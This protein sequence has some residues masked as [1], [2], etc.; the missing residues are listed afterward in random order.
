MES[1]EQDPQYLDLDVE[2]EV[3][4]SREVYLIGQPETPRVNLKITINGKLIQG[5]VDTGAERN[6]IHESLLYKFFGSC[7]EVKEWKNLVTGV[8][9]REGIKPI[10]MISGMVAIDG[11]KLE[12]SNFLVIP[13]KAK[14]SSRLILGMDFL[15]KQRMILI[16][17]D[18]V[19][20]HRAVDKSGY[21]WVIDSDGTPLELRLNQTSCVLSDNL[22]VEPH[23]TVSAKIK[24]ADGVLNAYTGSRK[25]LLLVESEVDEKSSTKFTINDGLVCSRE[26]MVMLTNNSNTVSKF[27][28][29]MQVCLA[30][31][32][33]EVDPDDDVE[34]ED[35]SQLSRKIVLDHLD[36]NRKSN[37]LDMLEQCRSVF[38]YSDTDV[39]AAAVTAHTIHLTDTTPVY[40]RPRRLPDP[41]SQEIDHQCQQLEAMDILERSTSSWSAQVVP[42]R[43]GDGS[44]RM[45][46][47]YRGLNAQT[48]PDRSPIPCLSD[49]VYGIQGRKFFTTVD[50]V[51]GYYQ[52]PLAPE[53][54]EYTAFSTASRHYQFKRL[55]F[56]LRNAPAAFQ[57]EI[58]GVLTD[59]S[60]T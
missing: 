39:N 41:V 40:M 51:K 32:V 19:L 31:S 21:D 38:S 52:V 50:L 54:R 1:D 16:P 14:M 11:I 3:I 58:Q 22:E 2:P 33:L 47:D 46:I 45:C 53:S 29:G 13:I 4:N 27:R 57:R 49:A 23:S 59:F 20:S 25:S 60:K 43:K 55:P 24:I 34:L 18:R 48:K 56:G 10:G 6:M 36:D 12:D 42:I 30:T 37:V 5:L 44:L 35:F 26:M 17:G 7:P 28:E 15:R 9:E 8:G